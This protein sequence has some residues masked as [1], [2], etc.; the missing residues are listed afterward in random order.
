MNLTKPK[1]ALITLGDSRKEFYQSR[2]HIVDEETQKVC[3]ALHTEFELY[4]PNVVYTEKES[5]T[6]ME[7][8]RRQGIHAV[9]IFLPI[10]GTPS[11]ALRIA[12]STTN[13]VLVLGNQRR[14]SSSLV[15]MLAV[16]GMLDQCGK[17]CL[18]VAGDISIAEIYEQVRQY[19]YACELAEKVRKS[20]FC[21]IGGRSIGIGT[22]V[23]DPSQWEKIFGTSFDH[24]D[25]FEIYYRAEAIEPERI[26][27][28]LKWWVNC[29]NIEYGGL[30]TQASL[31]RQMRSYLAI[32]DMAEE[33]NYDFLGIKCQQEMSTDKFT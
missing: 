12:Q 20:S 11:L 26:Q 32:K 16:A 2:I 31:E 6:V 7:E 9:I 8:I 30:F 33:R 10:W 24:A 13:P 4:A 3:A 27:R 23:A 29:I 22:T 19:I 17:K 18:R 25:Q 14:D 15:V 28:H 5:L 21:M 1:A